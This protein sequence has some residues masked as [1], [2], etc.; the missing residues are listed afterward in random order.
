MFFHQI[1]LI[2]PCATI[3]GSIM[4]M[5]SSANKTPKRALSLHLQLMIVLPLSNHRQVPENHSIPFDGHVLPLLEA[6]I[7]EKYQSYHPWNLLRSQT[8]EQDQAFPD[9]RHLQ[10]AFDQMRNAKCE[11]RNASIWLIN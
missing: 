3:Y 11:M 5:K 2:Q 7:E 9:E 4:L 6:G 1:E 8:W 10:V